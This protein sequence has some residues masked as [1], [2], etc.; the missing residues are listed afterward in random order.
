M[1][2]CGVENANGEET[3]MII[4]DG[5]DVLVH[6][7]HAHSLQSACGMHTVAEVLEIAAQKGVKTV[8]ICDHADASGRKMNFGVIANP[9]RTP[10]QVKI[11]TE[12]QPK[13]VRLLAGIE[14]NI[15]ENGNTDLPL[16]K[17]GSSSHD[18]ALVSAGF[19]PFAKEL[20]E[21]KNLHI[22]IA[23]LSS[24]VKRYPIDILTHPCIDSFP[25]PV[26][27]LVALAKEHH[28]ALEVNNTNLVVKKT[29]RKLLKEMITEARAQDVTLLC[30]SDGH[31]WHELFECG[32]VRDFIESKMKLVLEEVFPLNFGSWKQVCKRFP[33]IC[34]RLE[35]DVKSK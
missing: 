30:N 24:Y 9:E 33:N 34:R 20:K 26:G 5:R 32:A 28:F 19:H 16:A 11:S 22:N 3:H 10:M 14:A 8:N 18:F 7:F 12:D 29:N 25:L 15:L 4:A 31:T 27:E 2:K 1:S 6:D 23:A 35:K 17:M 13:E 21:W